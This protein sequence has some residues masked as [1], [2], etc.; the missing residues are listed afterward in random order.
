MLTQ[1]CIYVNM[2]ARIVI[3]S[4][5]IR[6]GGSIH[7]A[8]GESDAERDSDALLKNFRNLTK[9]SCIATDLDIR[10][11][12]VTRSKLSTTSFL[13]PMFVELWRAKDGDAPARVGQGESGAALEALLVQ[14]LNRQDDRDGLVRDAPVKQTAKVLRLEELLLPH[15]TRQGRR[16]ALGQHLNPLKVNLPARKHQEF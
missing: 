4:L 16:P 12:R 6:S 1:L 3:F 15:E 9:D 10:M 8:K 7:T 11:S 14:P 2:D 5:A 13:L